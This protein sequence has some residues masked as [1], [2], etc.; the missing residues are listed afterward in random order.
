MT[1]VPR[2]TSLCQS[3]GVGRIFGGLQAPNHDKL[4]CSLSN[5]AV[6]AF[7]MFVRCGWDEPRCCEHWAR[8]SYDD[9]LMALDT[10]PPYLLLSSETIEQSAEL[11]RP[12]PSGRSYSCALQPIGS[13]TALQP[14]GY[15]ATNSTSV[16]NRC[17][18]PV[19]CEFSE[20]C[21]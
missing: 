7:W 11:L 17:R 1:S 18:Y 3:T 2:H 9:M 5:F 6:S 10:I 21:P 16:K 15:H 12:H 8:L 20:V 19:F 13:T 14:E 4:C